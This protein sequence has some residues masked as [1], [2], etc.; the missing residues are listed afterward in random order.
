MN[1]NNI[2]LSE[3]TV[4]GTSWCPDCSRLKRILNENTIVFTE[5][6]VDKDEKSREKLLQAAQGE[7]S[8]PWIDVGG[9]MVRGWHKEF[10]GKWNEQTFF[11]ELEIAQAK[12][13]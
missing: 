5:F 10:P 2:R 7:F 3:V 4:Y 13:K 8:V 9:T 12:K 6:D 11:S 1:W